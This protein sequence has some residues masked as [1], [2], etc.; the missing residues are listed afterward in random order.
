MVEDNFNDPQKQHEPYADTHRP[1][2]GGAVHDGRHLARKHR[3]VWFCNGDKEAHHK[4]DTQQDAHFFGL[5]EAFA[6]VLAHGGHGHIGPHIEQADAENEEEGR[7]QKNP[8][9][10]GGNLYPGGYGEGKNQHNDRNDGD[11]SLFQF[12]QQRPF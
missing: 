8:Q 6:N 2:E 5:G 1:D 10:F 12:F 3:Q 7:N 9:L 4:A 11:Q